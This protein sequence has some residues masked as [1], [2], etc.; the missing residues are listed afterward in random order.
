MMGSDPL[1]RRC[2][3]AAKAPARGLSPFLAGALAVLLTIQAQARDPR[4]SNL[5]AQDA[6]PAQS[7]ERKSTTPAS[8]FGASLAA[9]ARRQTSHL[10]FYNPAYM[11]I[12]YPMGDVPSYMGVCTDVVVRAYRA[13]GIDLQ[14]LVHNSG[15]GSGDTNIDHRRVEVLRRFFARAGTSLPI[16]SNAS[17]YKPGDIV[18]YYMPNGWLSKTHIAI[19]ADERSATGTP[20]VVHNRGWGVQAEDWLFAEKITGH[21]RYAG[22]R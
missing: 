18:T 22:A 4:R 7:T 14:V 20:L 11:K 13:L 15:A 17:D 12:G 9:V 1:P 8:D 10:V 3:C 16:T 2:G 5:G 6:P 19:V 21:F